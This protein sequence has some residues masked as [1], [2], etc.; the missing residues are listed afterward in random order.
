MGLCAP[1]M[2]KIEKYYQPS[3]AVKSLIQ[4]VFIDA[5]F[6]SGSALEQEYS[7]EVRKA[8]SSLQSLY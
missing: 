7:S 3:R 6:V 8:L 2:K 1:H 4:Q 5:Y